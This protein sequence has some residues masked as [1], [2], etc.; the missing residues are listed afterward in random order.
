MGSV[1]VVMY[2]EAIRKT[3][4]Y[5]GALPPGVQV[6]YKPYIP[7]SELIDRWLLGLCVKPDTAPRGKDN[8]YGCGIPFAGLVASALKTAGA[9][10]VDI[11]SS[12]APIFAIGLMGA[13][14]SGM[15]KG[16]QSRV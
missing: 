7:P 13:M 15:F 11:F 10:Q 4:T 9:A 12:I 6:E 5:P 16:G 14:I 8:E 3:L 1:M 2:Q